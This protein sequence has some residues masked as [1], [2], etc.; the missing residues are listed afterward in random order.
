MPAVTLLHRHASLAYAAVFV[1][2]LGHGSSEFVA[3]YSGI[4]GAE[5]SVWRYVLGAA[6]MLIWALA[7]PASRDLLA[8]LR[9]HGMRILLL[10]LLG[11]SIPYLL[12]HVAL[13]F[14]TVI[15]VATLV[16][17]SP[18][19]VGLLNLVLNRVPFTAPKIISGLCAFAGVA[20]LVTDGYVARLAGGSTSLVGMLMVMASSAM[21]SAYMVLSKP[22][23]NEFGAI[24][25]IT[26]TMTIGAVA[27][28][29]VVGVWWGKWIDPTTL[30]DRAPRESW[31]LLT[32]G[33][34]NTTITQIIW[35]AGLAAVPD[36]TRGSYLF[37]LKPVIAAVLA[38]LILSQ[39]ITVF[40]I[41]AMAVILGSVLVELFWPKIVALK[42][43]R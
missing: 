7:L 14:A 41:G 12:F 8:P 3:V 18:I 1:G 26:V 33:I 20:L 29:L 6:G 22:L 36:I 11:V 40:Q 17:V 43:A 10:S 42:T 39:P 13:D 35:L 15:Q 25:I 32:I 5:V 24:R 31:S 2:V 23:I 28:W 21:I 27:L 9:A 16:T 30:F 19:F 37:F 4:A 34:W 38:L